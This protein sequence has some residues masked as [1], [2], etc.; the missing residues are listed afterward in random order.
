MLF[1]GDIML[2][3]SRIDMCRAIDTY[4]INYSDGSKFEFVVS[5]GQDGKTPYIGDNG[6]WWIG[7]ED[8]GVF[9]VSFTDIDPE[10]ARDVVNYVVNLL[11]ER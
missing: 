9:T 1:G 11:E 5:N 2:K 3:Y 10:F 6:N 4:V 7:D 8:T